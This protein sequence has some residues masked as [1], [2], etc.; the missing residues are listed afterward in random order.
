[1]LCMGVVNRIRSSNV[2]FSNWMWS[3]YWKK[4]QPP[5]NWEETSDAVLRLQVTFSL[6]CSPDKQQK[7]KQKCKWNQP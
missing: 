5:N 4:K 6:M 2:Y 3:L 7:Q 1:M